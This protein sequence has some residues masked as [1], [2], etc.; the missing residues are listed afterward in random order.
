M[1]PQAAKHE[2]NH[3]L[4]RG[5][6][7][8]R[9]VIIKHQVS[10]PEVAELQVAEHRVVGLGAAKPKKIPEKVHNWIQD[11]FEKSPL[12]CCQLPPIEILIQQAT[13]TFKDPFAI[14]LVIVA[15]QGSPFPAGK[16]IRI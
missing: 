4:R 12:S 11:L 2:Q 7:P 9:R 5:A 14:R 13:G 10:E 8:Q 16:E 1:A 3:I 15:Q 6:N